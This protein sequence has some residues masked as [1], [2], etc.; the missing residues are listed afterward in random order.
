M[1]VR[2]AFFPIKAVVGENLFP[3]ILSNDHSHPLVQCTKNEWSLTY[4]FTFFFCKINLAKLIYT[5]IMVNKEGIKR[6]KW[7]VYRRQIVLKWNIAMVM[8]MMIKNNSNNY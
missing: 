5:N 2:Y 6:K 1:C 3:A 7:T 4:L 8:T